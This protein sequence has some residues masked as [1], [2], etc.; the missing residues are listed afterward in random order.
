MTSLSQLS[1]QI[2]A[3]LNL[4][5]FVWTVLAV[6]VFGSV[7]CVEPSPPPAPPP[8]ITV[9]PVAY[10]PLVASAA[11]VPVA[12]APVPKG[13]L[14]ADDLKFLEDHGPVLQLESAEHGIVAVSAKYQGR[15]MT[16]AVARD[17]TSIGY[18]NRPFITAGKTGTAFDNY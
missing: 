18:I 3:A 2:P 10:T 13:P 14:F 5:R 12:A 11:P 4:G 17:N 9:P 16:S 1:R 7:G 6:G 8:Q 15:V